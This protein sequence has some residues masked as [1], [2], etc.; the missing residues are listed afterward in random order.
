MPSDSSI[1]DG[2]LLRAFSAFAEAK[3][4]TRA[5]KSVGLSQPALF[6]RVKRLSDSVGATLYEKRGRELALTE[7]GRK[8]AAFAHEALQRAESFELELRGE[9]EPESVCLAAGEGSFLYLLGPA[10]TAFMRQGKSR[11]RLL[12]LGAVNATEAVRSGEADLAVA[13]LDLVPRGL[14]ATEVLRTHLCAAMQPSHPLA[15]RSKVTLAELAR[16]QLVLPPPGRTHR[17][18]VGRAIGR[19][20]YELIL[21]LEADGWPLM[22][23]FA[24]LGLGVAVVNRFC[25]L[26]E[27]VVAR[28]IPELGTLV[29]R[30]LRRRP[31]SPR[32][33][34]DRLE[35][36]IIA[37]GRRSR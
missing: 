17:D 10:I 32:P 19:L 36:Q 20:G 23:Q 3:N 9:P 37:L 2:D 30:L 33:E 7:A 22:L 16:E 14:V 15:R 6:E 13:A 8:V 27:G 26:P 4:F 34:V 11:L 1:L 31:T 28:P 21:P 12:T 35:A 24:A 5:A 18:F 25:A 29:Y